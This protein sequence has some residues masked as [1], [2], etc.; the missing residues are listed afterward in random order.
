MEITLLAQS[1]IRIKG[2][3]GTLVVNPSSDIKGKVAA[4]AILLTIPKAPI[5]ANK[6]EGSRVTIM[7]VGEYEVSGIKITGHQSNNAI[8]Y[9]IAVDQTHVLLGKVSAIERVKDKFQGAHVV[10]L[11]ADAICDEATL[12]TLEPAAAVFFGEKTN[13]IKLAMHHA[14]HP[15]TKYQT[16][17]ITD[18]AAK[19]MELIW[20]M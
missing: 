5:V 13:E 20:L 4:D 10:V 7:G 8:V 6:L 19:E 14:G 11:E 16:T 2:K 15:T 1:S 3:K 17:T 9:Q 18:T 12:A